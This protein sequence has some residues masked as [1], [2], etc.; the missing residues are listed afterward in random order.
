MIDAIRFNPSNGSFICLA[1]YSIQQIP[2]N[3][4][5]GL[6]PLSVQLV[7]LVQP[8]RHALRVGGDP[9]LGGLFGFGAFGDGEHH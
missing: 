8:A 6:S 7:G 3:K 1:A 4:K 2:A 5:A 9:V